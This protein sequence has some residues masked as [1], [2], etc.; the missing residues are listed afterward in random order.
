M[1]DGTSGDN[2]VDRLHCIFMKIHNLVVPCAAFVD[3]KVAEEFPFHTSSLLDELVSEMTCYSYAVEDDMYQ[4]R[5][6]S[7]LVYTALDKM[8]HGDYRWIPMDFR[9][10][11]EEHRHRVGSTEDINQAFEMYLRA[12]KGGI[13]SVMAEY[14][15]FNVE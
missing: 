14:D 9:S 15:A 6:Q 13:G 8:F 7:N 4:D 3:A 2:F 1:E 12:T 11:D 5:I 10:G